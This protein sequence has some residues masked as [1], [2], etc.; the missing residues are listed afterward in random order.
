MNVSYAWE[1]I[2]RV[3]ILNPETVLKLLRPLV[4]ILPI[5]GVIYIVVF[6]EGHIETIIP[7]GRLPAGIATLV[8]ILPSPLRL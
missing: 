2:S 4:E 3:G 1:L 6:A 5:E 7:V 8:P